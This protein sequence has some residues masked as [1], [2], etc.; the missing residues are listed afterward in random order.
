ME[1]AFPED[2]GQEFTAVMAPLIEA[3]YFEGAGVFRPFGRPAPV[4][5]RGVDF[6][7]TESGRS[8]AEAVS[9]WNETFGRRRNR[10]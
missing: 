9:V 5:S 7:L 1:E 8:R 4:I 10:R 3:G 6:R 2:A